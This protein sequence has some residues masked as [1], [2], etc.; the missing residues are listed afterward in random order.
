MLICLISINSAQFYLY[1]TCT[2]TKSCIRT[3][4]RFLQLPPPLG[5]SASSSMLPSARQPSIAPAC[6]PTCH[7]LLARSYLPALPAY[8]ACLPAYLLSFLRPCVPACLAR[9]KNRPPEASSSSVQPPRQARIICTACPGLWRLGQGNPAWP[10]LNCSSHFHFSFASPP[11]STHPRASRVGCA[12]RL[13]S[14]PSGASHSCV[15]RSD[16][17][18]DSARLRR[19]K[20]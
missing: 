7:R 16:N 14:R 13:I 2:R 12:H 4:Q 3:P 8:L 18:A 9:H 6:P 5:I 11:A 15:P 17:S 10:S 20:P 1:L 19:D